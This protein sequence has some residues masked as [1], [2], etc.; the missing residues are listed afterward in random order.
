MSSLPLHLFKDSSASF[1]EALSANGVEFSRR[2]QL[3]EAP[4]AAGW[5]IEVFSAVKEATPWGALAVVIVA[6]LKAKSSRKVIITT[7]DNTVVHVEGFSI[8]QVAKVLE[9]AKDAAI[10]D[11]PPTKDGKGSGSGK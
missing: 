3:T 2:I 7:R 9:S 4:M 6:W 10:I 1:T 8:E 11:V 5:V